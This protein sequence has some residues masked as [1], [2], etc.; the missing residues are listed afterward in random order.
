MCQAWWVSM[1]VSSSKTSLLFMIFR[2]LL[3]VFCPTSAVKVNRF[4]HLLF[5]NLSQ[6]S[7]HSHPLFSFRSA[8][9]LSNFWCWSERV[10][11]FHFLQF[12]SVFD[13]LTSSVFY[14]FCYFFWGPTFAARVNRFLHF[15][16][17]SS[18]PASIPSPPWHNIHFYFVMT[19]FKGSLLGI[20]FLL[21]IHSRVRH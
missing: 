11:A 10:S 9:F 21:Y 13:P 17:Y 15:I 3:L 19:I 2:F 12:K 14:L 20:A 16:L 6:V 1:S 7:T 18:S 4:L 8:S 5:Y